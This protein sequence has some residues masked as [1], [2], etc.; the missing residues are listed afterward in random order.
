MEEEYAAVDSIGNSGI[1]AVGDI[2][3]LNGGQ[4]EKALDK[5]MGVGAFYKRSADRNYGS[6]QYRGARLSRHG[7]TNYRS[8][9][10]RGAGAS[11][12]RFCKAGYMT[13]KY[14]TAIIPQYTPYNKQALPFKFI[15]SSE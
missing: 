10:A 9:A 4:N 13:F 8:S 15:N 6:K 11:G 3:I 14:A 1:Y 5:N 2:C 7:N 12:F